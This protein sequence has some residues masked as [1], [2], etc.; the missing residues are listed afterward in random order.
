MCIVGPPKP[1]ETRVATAH[2]KDS[3]VAFSDH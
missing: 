2:M 3:P 1:Y